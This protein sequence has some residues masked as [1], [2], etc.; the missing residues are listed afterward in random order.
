VGE[1][2]IHL[3]LAV[4][5]LEPE[6]ASDARGVVGVREAVEVNSLIR[7]NRRR[8]D[9]VVSYDWTIDDD[10]EDLRALAGA[11]YVSSRAASILLLETILEIERLTR[12]AGEVDDNVDAFRDCEA[13]TRYLHGFL[14]QVAVGRDLPE[15]LGR[16]VWSKHK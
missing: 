4:A 14:Q 7:W 3:P 16:V 10:L 9:A 2:A 1:P 12:L 13:R 5:S 11:E 8:I 15:R 6:G